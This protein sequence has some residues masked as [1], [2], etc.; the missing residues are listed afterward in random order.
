MARTWTRRGSACG[1]G[2]GYGCGCS[3]GCGCGCW[4]GALT[5]SPRHFRWPAAP[6]PIR[7][8]PCHRRFGGGGGGGC[9]SRP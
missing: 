3:C 4:G 5:R 7:T 1:A 2:A 9:V 8:R 6:D